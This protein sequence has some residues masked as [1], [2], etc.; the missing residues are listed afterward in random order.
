[1]RENS[2]LSGVSDFF[3]GII[4][5]PL[6]QTALDLYKQKTAA[7]IAADQARAQAEAE[8]ARAKAAADAAKAA[9]KTST[10]SPG[11]GIDPKLILYGVAGLVGLG[12]IVW[13]ARRA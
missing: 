13:A 7:E 6:G 4:E 10:G 2:F 3:G 12:V 9:A 5:S 8:R 11:G 1:M